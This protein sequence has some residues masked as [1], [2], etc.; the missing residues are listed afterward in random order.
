MT[1]QDKDPLQPYRAKRNADATPEPFGSTEARAQPSAKAARRFMIHHHAARNTHYD[2]RLEMDG[3]LRSWA[4]PKGP[5]PNMQE[6]RYAARVEDHPLEYGD[7]E[8][9]IPEGNYGAGWTIVWDRGSWHCKGD[10]LVGL[11]KGKLL[12]ELRGHKLH[13]MWTLVKMKSADKDWLFIKERD[14]HSSDVSTDHYPSGSVFSGMSL[15]DLDAGIDPAQPL[16]AQIGKLAVP[17]KRTRQSQPRLMLATP[18][19]PFTK[20]GWL[21]EIKYDG[22]RLLCEKDEDETRLVSRNGNDLSNTFP[23]IVQA[24]ARLPFKQLIIDGEAVIHDSNGLP[25][26]TNMQQRGD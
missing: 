6:R 17:A 2:L 19:E 23:E 11:A 4:I 15:V 9:H 14:E 12:F 20:R 25:S 7:F 8:G 26:F 18:S 10:P 5:S 21:F 22:Y 1:T 3:V 24:L 13:G 16:L